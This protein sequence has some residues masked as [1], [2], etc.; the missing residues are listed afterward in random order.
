MQSRF[1]P[2]PSLPTTTITTLPLDA[3][4]DSCEHE[5]ALQQQQTF[6][7]LCQY[8]Y[9]NENNRTR[10]AIRL[11]VGNSRSRQPSSIIYS[12]KPDSFGAY[13]LRLVRHQVFEPARRFIHNSF[14]PHR[15]A[16]GEWLSV[17]AFA[18]SLSRPQRSTLTPSISL[19]TL[20][21]I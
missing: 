8:L 5:T 6:L 12:L 2:P 1:P 19:G 10:A 3:L 9:F 17:T 18:G 7:K 11:V 16:L 14:S 21:T 20:S 13:I 15:S 4:P